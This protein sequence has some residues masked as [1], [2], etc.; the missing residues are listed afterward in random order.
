MTEF[1]EAPVYERLAHLGKA[2]SAPVRLRLLDLLDQG[3]CTVEE[4][5]QRGGFPLKNTSSHLQQLRAAGL[6]A[7]RREG[8]R[9]HYSLRDSEVSRFLG[10]F[11]EFA[12]ARMPDLRQEI[13]E[14]LGPEGS[15]DAV[16]HAE[17]DGMVERGEV[18]LVDLRSA[19]EYEEGHLPGAVSVPS[20]EL[21]DRWAELPWD[22]T[23]VA[24]CQ[25]PYCVVSPRAVRLLREAGRSARSLKG[26]YV[27]WKRHHDSADD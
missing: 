14:H 12:E 1:P 24:Y 8:T 5:A 21:A 16:T 9:I 3:E 27:D 18:L 26:G 20:R 7:T 17:L 25:G 4:L 13:Q 19:A 10:R 2:L 11:Q 23:I 22:T 15:V 6:V